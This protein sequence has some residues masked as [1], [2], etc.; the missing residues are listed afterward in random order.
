MILGRYFTGKNIEETWQVF[1]ER[2]GFCADIIR[3]PPSLLA[4]LLECLPPLRTTSCRKVV[5]HMTAARG[6]PIARTLL[7]C[8]LGVVGAPQAFESGRAC[9]AFD[10]LPHVLR[11][12]P[13]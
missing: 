3:R 9:R 11:P 10:P 12:R 8:S 7:G 1:S 4:L 13:S 2:R 6:V 5:W